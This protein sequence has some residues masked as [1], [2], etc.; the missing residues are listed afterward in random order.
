MC[1]SKICKQRNYFSYIRATKK[2][3]AAKQIKQAQ[4][5][6]RKKRGS[7]QITGLNKYPL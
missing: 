5:G 2:N 1:K 6:L 3:R 4:S 7:L